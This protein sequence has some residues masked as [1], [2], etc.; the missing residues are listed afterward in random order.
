MNKGGLGNI[1]GRPQAQQTARASELADA[2][3]SSGTDLQGYCTTRQVQDA[4]Y[5]ENQDIEEPPW[6]E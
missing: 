3:A 2:I 5:E 4:G 6:I 1:P